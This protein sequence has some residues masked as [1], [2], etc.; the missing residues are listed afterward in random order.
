MNRKKR[1]SVVLL[2]AGV[3]LLVVGLLYHSEPVLGDRGE[4]VKVDEPA[5]V[6][7]ITVGGVTRNEL[8][9]LARTYSGEQ[10][11]LCPT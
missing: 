10:P 8:G 1:V 7:E 4:A 3:I 2:A 6:R 11:D 5:L 9:E